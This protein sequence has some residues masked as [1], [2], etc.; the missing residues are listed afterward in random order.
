MAPTAREIEVMDHLVEGLSNKRIAGR[1][2]LSDHTVKFHVANT[3][4]KLD[5]PTRSGGAVKHAMA[6]IID[7][8]PR[9]AS[10]PE[11]PA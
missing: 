11:V 2:A 3:L 8:C 5:A 4:A 1:L 7:G 9:C 6:K 10:R